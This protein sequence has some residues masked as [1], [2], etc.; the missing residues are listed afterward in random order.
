V[1]GKGDPVELSVENSGAGIPEEKR[2]QL[3]QEFSPTKTPTQPEKGFGMGLYL[4]R[5]M[6][7]A[8]GAR[9]DCESTPGQF[10]RFTIHL[11]PREGVTGQGK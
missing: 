5:L 10:T 11:A 1:D 8:N 6:S 4:C 9:I 3:F 7:E 2:H